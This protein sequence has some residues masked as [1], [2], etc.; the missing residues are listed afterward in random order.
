MT[1]NDFELATV[2]AALRTFQIQR[3]ILNLKDMPQFSYGI[4]ALPD[5]EIDDLCER[6]NCEKD[7]KTFYALAVEEDD[8]YS[9]IKDSFGVPAN[10]NSFEGIKID[11]ERQEKLNGGNLS[12][13]K[14]E[15]IE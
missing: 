14:C 13:L 15:V 5:K 3:D 1:F 10:R 2:L 8:S 11:K 4:R 7:I 6:L 9:I 12:I